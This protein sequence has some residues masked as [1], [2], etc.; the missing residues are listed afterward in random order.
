MRGAFVWPNTAR[1]V[2]A[3][4][5]AQP[6]RPNPNSPVLSHDRA[7]P[8]HYQSSSRLWSSLYRLSL[9]SIGF[10][11]SGSLRLP[12]P[13]VG[14]AAV[15]GQEFDACGLRHGSRNFEQQRSDAYNDM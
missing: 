4:R 13:H 1:G 11:R 6:S 15:F 12:E 7:R 8:N 2:T 5:P 9:S 3:W 10:A 14:A